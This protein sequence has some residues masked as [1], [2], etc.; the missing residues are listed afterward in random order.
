MAF[1]LLTLSLL[2]CIGI[3]PARAQ[4]FDSASVIHRVDAAAQARFDNVSSYTVTEHYAIF[5]N[6][7]VT[8]PAAEM[9]VKT[10]Y[11]KGIG[12]DYTILSQ[13]GS[14]LLQK[15]VLAPLLDTEKNINLPGNIEK[16]WI[17]SANYDMTLKPGGIQ[18]LYGRDCLVIAM[19]PKQKAPNMIEGSLWVD[20]NDGSIVQIDGI[21]SRSPSFFSGSPKVMRQYANMSGFPMAIHARAQSQSMLF[22]PTILTIDYSDYQVQLRSAN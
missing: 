5:R 11:R 6:N 20:A 19:N 2:Q 1:L 14:E 18:R 8:H 13:T 9:T 17:V 4:Q 12:K 22:G 7:D 15:F 3:I 16:S 10:L 21:A